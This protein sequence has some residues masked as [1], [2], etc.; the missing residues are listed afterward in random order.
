MLLYCLVLSKQPSLSSYMDAFPEC[1]SQLFPIVL[2]EV[3][4]SSLATSNLR[5]LKLFR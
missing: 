2:C 5:W 4:I 3:L 1:L